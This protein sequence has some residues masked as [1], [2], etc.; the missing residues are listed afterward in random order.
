MDFEEWHD[1]TSMVARW[2]SVITELGSCHYVLDTAVL[3]DT[4]RP[5]L[6]VSNYRL[7]HTIKA[8]QLEI[9]EY[10]YR[11]ERHHDTLPKPD[12]YEEDL[13]DHEST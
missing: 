3:H 1:M 10:I 13:Y 5:D 9:E 8:L 4:G 7:Y 11:L 12:N 6:A 2:C